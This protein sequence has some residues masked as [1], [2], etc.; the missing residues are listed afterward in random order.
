M[1]FLTD[2]PD[3]V[4]AA[5]VAGPLVLGATGVAISGNVAHT[6]DVGHGISI[7]GSISVDA[8]KIGPNYSGKGLHNPNI[9]GGSINIKVN[10]R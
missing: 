8:G 10:F 5:M 4:G 3:L 6:F 7:T 1:G 2:H 9:T